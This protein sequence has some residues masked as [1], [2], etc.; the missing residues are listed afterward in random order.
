MA[1]EDRFWCEGDG[2][3]VDKPE[4]RYIISARIADATG[5][6]YVTVFNDQVRTTGNCVGHWLLLTQNGMALAESMTTGRCTR[7][8][9]LAVLEGLLQR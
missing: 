3:Y 4:H 7:G 9:L 1:Q 2:C 8:C 5:E 6:M